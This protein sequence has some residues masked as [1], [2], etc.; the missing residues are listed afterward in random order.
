M[1]QH[2]GGWGRLVSK[3]DRQI[4]GLALFFKLLIFMLIT[5]LVNNY[6]VMAEAQ[7]NCLKWVSPSVSPT[8]SALTDAQE[9]GV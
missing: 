4:G 5:G 3:V 8:C 7:E 1:S 6:L 9:M 2:G